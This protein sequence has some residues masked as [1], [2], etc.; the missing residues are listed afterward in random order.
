[1]LFDIQHLSSSRAV[2]QNTHSLAGLHCLALT[3]SEL[4]PS[5]L[6]TANSKMGDR[7]ILNP[8]FAL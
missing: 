7:Q 3:M 5:L 1:M 8:A 6:Q 4:G 2:V